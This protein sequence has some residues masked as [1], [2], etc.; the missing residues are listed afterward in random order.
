MARTK[1]IT[2]MD[3]EIAKVEKDLVNAGTDDLPPGVT[4]GQALKRCL[5]QKLCKVHTKTTI[6]S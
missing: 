4:R 6:H 1:S 5:V 3:A 2:S